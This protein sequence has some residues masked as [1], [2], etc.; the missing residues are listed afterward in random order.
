MSEEWKYQVRSELS[1]ELAEKARADSTRRLRASSALASLEK[2][3]I[4][5]S[6]LTPTIFHEDWWLNI[7]TKGAYEVVEVS[8]G[9]KVV[10]R[11]PYHP[12]RKY[13]VLCATM[14]TLTHFLGPAIDDR[15]GGQSA[16]FTRRMEITHELLKKL[17]PLQ[18]IK[19]KCHRGIHDVIAFQDTK[20]RT[21]PQFT[22]EILPQ[23]ETTIWKNFRDKTRNSIRRVDDQEFD[24]SVDPLELTTFYKQ[25][26]DQKNQRN[27]LNLTV[28]LDLLRETLE[29]SAGKVYA[30]RDKSGDLSAAIFCV[31]DNT[32]FYYL[33]TTRSRRSG[34]GAI[35]FLIW[36]AIKEAAQ[37]NL[38]FDFDGLGGAGSILFYSGFGG[39]IEP[40]YVATKMSLPLKLVRDFIRGILNDE[41]Y[42]H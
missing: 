2:R 6:T 26:L 32:S 1:P 18:L 12:T 41:Q 38:V 40:R 35:A 28:C 17:P 29:R 15:D 10:G 14:P 19:I 16:R 21:S 8:D 39:N 25:N 7:A 20:F 36:Q 27:A 4:A 24:T 13:G 34:R 31:W 5:N 23:P 42:F 11:L 3:G 37:R 30:L 9:G 22:F 33:L